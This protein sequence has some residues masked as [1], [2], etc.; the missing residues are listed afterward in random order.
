MI[1]I[2][3]SRLGPLAIPPP[4]ITRHGGLDQKVKGSGAIVLS[5][6]KTESG[7]NCYEKGAGLRREGIDETVGLRTE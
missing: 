2:G 6:R 3:G 1:Q 7:R 4:R 5:L